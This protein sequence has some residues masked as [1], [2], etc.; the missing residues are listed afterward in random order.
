MLYA[1][2]AGR[3][4]DFISPLYHP[5][6]GEARKE[7]DEKGRKGERARVKG[8]IAKAKNGGNPPGRF[9][10]LRLETRN[11]ERGGGTTVSKGERGELRSVVSACVFPVKELVG[12][13]RHED[14]GREREKSGKRRGGD[15]DNAGK[16]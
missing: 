5:H 3:H 13:R 15:V 6:L 9:P 11:G 10:V 2:S 14:G 12:R 8:A 4:A 7:T 1:K 16:T